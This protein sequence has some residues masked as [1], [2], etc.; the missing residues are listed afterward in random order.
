MSQQI[1]DCGQ[2]QALRIDPEDV[3]GRG[4]RECLNV[5]LWIGWDLWTFKNE[6]MENRLCR[7]QLVDDLRIRNTTVSV[8]VG[9]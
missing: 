9:E 2:I 5:G 7:P 1:E 4:C 6:G 8:V 3:T